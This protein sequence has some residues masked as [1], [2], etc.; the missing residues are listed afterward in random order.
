LPRVI[1]DYSLTPFLH[2]PLTPLLHYPFQTGPFGT[3]LDNT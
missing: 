2:H 1:L 3:L